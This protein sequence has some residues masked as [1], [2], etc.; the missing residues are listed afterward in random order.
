MFKKTLLYV[1]GGKHFLLLA[2]ALCCSLLA[3]SQNTQRITG[4]VVDSLDNEPLPGVA[5]SV[6]GTTIGTT[7]DLNGR[8]VINAIKGT[9]LVFRY[10]GYREK[11]VNI[12]DGSIINVKLS[13]TTQSLDQV[14]VI[15]YGTQKKESV[16]AA[17]STVSAKDIVRTPT[18]NLLTGLAGKLPGL[19]IMVKD[20][21]LG[22]E[23]V[24]TL[25]RGQATTNSSA[26]LILVDGVER[27][28]TTL[29]P[30]DIESI[31]VL[32]DASATA[33]FGVRG[34][35]GVILVTSKRGVIGAPS[36]TG[37]INYST[38][39]PTRLPKP[40]NAIDYMTVR[41]EVIRQDNESRGL[42]TPIPYP[43]Q[44]FD[45][46]KTGYLPEFYVNRDFFGDFLKDYAP[47]AKTNFNIRGGNK[48]TKYFV[49]AG[50]L[51]QAGPFKTEK[52]DEYNY[53]NSEK[54]NRFNY[55]TNVDLQIT[56]S[57]KGWLN[58]SGYLEDKNDP[59][60]FGEDNAAATTGSNYYLLLANLT[61]LTALAFPDLNSEG[62]VVSTPG[63]PRTPYGSL[64]RT[65]YR[66]TTDN[67]INTSL[68]LEQDLKVITKGLSA[69]V[70]ASYDTKA[71]H[72]RGFRRTYQ[73]Y[74]AQLDNSGSEPQ[75]FY[76]PGSGSDI[77]LIKALTQR[78]TDNFDLE[79]S[80][81]YKRKFNKH[82]ITGLLLYKK[83]QRVVDAEVPFNYVGIV[84]RT[85]YAYD[86]K[87]L[88]EFNFGA[89]GSEQF[90]PGK[91]FGFFPSV[92]AGWVASEEP[93]LKSF[94]AIEFL[95][96]RGS[97]GQ[98]G[99]DRISDSRFIYLDDWAQGT[100]GGWLKKLGSLPGLPN[101][102]YQNTTPNEAVTWE[103]ANKYNIGFESR[104]LKGF[105]LDLDLFYEKRNSILITNVPIPTFIFGQQSLPPRNDGVMT[106][107]GFEA[108]LG[109]SKSVNKD[110]Y[111]G[112]RLSTAFARNKVE[113]FNE[114]PNDDSYAYPY[115]RE[116]FSNSTLWGYDY[117]GYFNSVE[118]IN[119]WADESALGSNI[120]P[121]DLKYRDANGDGV[122]NEKDIVPMS[123]PS[124]PELNVSLTLT[125]QYKAF[126]INVLF[127]GVSNYGFNMAGRGV[128]DWEGVAYGGIK[129]YFEHHKNA[130]SAEKVANGEPFWYPRMHPDGSSV[131]KQDNNFFI[132][133]LSFARLKNLEFGYTLGKKTTKKLGL[134]SLRIYFNG[135]NLL[136]VDNLPVKFADPE[137]AT[138]LS[139]PINTT[140]NFGLNVSF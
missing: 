79:A 24:Q 115:R 82:D 101:P 131:S 86:N 14:V 30:Y 113:K 66:I 15:G 60:V 50:Y 7:T 120:L 71:T 72:I 65:G 81:N 76:T 49:S 13:R 109:Y 95:K 42:S 45:Y 17:I 57:L 33:V 105:E 137:V 77:E 118:E 56:K 111:L 54:L 43:K 35:N 73:T 121:G 59:I 84:G 25:I 51:K 96:F 125:A 85:T 12:R 19:T 70:I 94:Q 5:I 46:Y 93:F 91:R 37:T 8:F 41:N 135:A 40:L 1:L 21:E 119:N 116:G 78:F 16:V 103:V 107:R 133:D 83:N 106:N 123:S 74:N 99:N 124:I 112:T 89:N 64:N 55:R 87:Y 130:W 132:R 3:F 39:S 102:V 117:L 62:N 122:I 58:L 53:D 68:G 18:A 10:I 136:L 38:Q 80:L 92:S 98:V 110:L 9:S 138:S 2:V 4:T 129:N 126:D 31:S 75:V 88:A 61:D 23:N 28:I 47:M 108:T 100:N 48:K 11:T 34:A 104:F 32:K 6:S 36:I 114:T 52:W 26:P 27:E 69:K 20:G 140:Y 134:S 90:A 67:N 63:A 139:H 22:K 44:I 97:F 128:Y 127:Y 29:D